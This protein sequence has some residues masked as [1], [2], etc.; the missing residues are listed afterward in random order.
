MLGTRSNRPFKQ[1][2]DLSWCQRTKLIVLALAGVPASKDAK[3]RTAAYRAARAEDH[4]PEVVFDVLDGYDAEGDRVDGILDPTDYT[5]RL[6]CKPPPLFLPII[7]L[8]QVNN[9]IQ[10]HHNLSAKYY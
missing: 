7:S 10:V 9:I 1:W 6:S 8:V 3:R 4:E 2:K 5:E